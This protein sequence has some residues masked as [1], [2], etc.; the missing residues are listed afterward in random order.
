MEVVVE[1]CLVGY[2]R[3]QHDLCGLRPG[4][5]GG[6]DAVTLIGPDQPR[7][8]SYSNVPVAI[9]VPGGFQW[10]RYGRGARSARGRPGRKGICGDKSRNFREGEESPQ[11]LIAR[12]ST[13]N[14]YYKVG[15]FWGHYTE[16]HLHHGRSE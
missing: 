15:E 7:R 2:A 11:C 8:I 4:N 3:S 1:E 10:E 5:A 13:G 6:I 16:F 9:T 14:V 12:S